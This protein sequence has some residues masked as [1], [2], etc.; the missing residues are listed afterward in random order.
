MG[1]SPPEDSRLRDLHASGRDPGFTGIPR[2]NCFFHHAQWSP[3]NRTPAALQ[4]TPE[5]PTNAA[6]RPTFD[7][8]DEGFLL[9]TYITSHKSQAGARNPKRRAEP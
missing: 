7:A 5:L 1:T 3:N 8:A 4:K 2:W 9:K 6:H